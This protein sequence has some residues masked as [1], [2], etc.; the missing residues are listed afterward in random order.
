[1]EKWLFEPLEDISGKSKNMTIRMNNKQEEYLKKYA[2]MY[3]GDK[4]KNVSRFV[5]MAIDY[6]ISH[7]IQRK[8]YHTYNNQTIIIPKPD[9]KAEKTLNS[10]ISLFNINNNINIINEENNSERGKHFLNPEFK[11]YSPNSNIDFEYRNVFKIRTLNNYFDI[12]EDGKYRANNLLYRHDGLII[13]G[14]KETIYLIRVLED[15]DYMYNTYFIKIDTAIELATESENI[16]LIEKL[17]EIKNNQFTNNRLLENKEEIKNNKALSKE[18]YRKTELY[19]GKQKLTKDKK[20]EI[21]KREIEREQFMPRPQNYKKRDQI[22]PTGNFNKD[23]NRD[24]LGRK[25]LS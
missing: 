21:I 8:K 11:E 3:F 2:T 15:W 23:T 4:K 13:E 10:N 24:E 19:S 5:R 25:I 12:W 20:E 9:L 14:W 16:E 6:F 7:H 1:M 22:V 17:I 18:E